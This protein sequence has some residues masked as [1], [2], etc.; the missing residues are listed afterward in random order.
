M[1]QK[2]L[3]IDEDLT[4]ATKLKQFLA[5]QFDVFVATSAEEGQV[6]FS[7]EYPC[8]IILELALP[9]MSG[10]DFCSWVRQQQTA[11]VSIIVVSN[12]Q[13]V[14]DKVLALT[15]GADDYLTKPVNFDELLAHIHAVLRR[16]GLFCQKI[17]YDGLCMKPRTGEVLLNGQAIGLT[18]HEFMLLYLL[19]SH[20]NQIITRE[21]LLLHLYPNL[22]KEILERSIDAHIKKLRAKIEEN[23]KKPQR[24]LTV[25][26]V[27][28]KFVA[29]VHEKR[30]LH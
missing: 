3:I 28:Y 5:P 23:P 18:K 13:L 14:S 6:K 8:L 29:N 17:I 30:S 16:T 11:D 25:R 12:K 20:P 1:K 10:E 2:I 19:M 4:L 27:G 9:T 15:L 24:L 22:E 26:A 7:T 21:D